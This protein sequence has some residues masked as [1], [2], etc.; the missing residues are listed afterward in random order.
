MTSMLV[1]T[2]IV[3]DGKIVIALE[4]GYNLRSLVPSALETVKVLLGEP[5]PCIP[6]Q[7][8][9]YN[10]FTWTERKRHDGALKRFADVL[11]RVMY[12]QSRFWNCFKD[13]VPRTT[14]NQSE[15][16]TIG[17]GDEEYIFFQ[18]FVKNST[19]KSYATYLGRKVKKI[20]KG[21]AMHGNVIQ[22]IFQQ[23]QTKWMIKYIDGS[24]RIMS[25][26]NMLKI[27]VGED[28]DEDSD[29]F[30]DM[31]VEIENT[32][33]F[34]GAANE[35]RYGRKS[36]KTGGAYAP[37]KK[38]LAPPES[39]EHAPLP[40]A[41]KLEMDQPYDIK[42]FGLQSPEKS[43]LQPLPRNTKHGFDDLQGIYVQDGSRFPVGAK[44]KRYT[45]D[46]DVV[47]VDK[48]LSA[49]SYAEDDKR[50]NFRAF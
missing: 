42:S 30:D 40:R 41:P 29:A 19:C 16:P 4:G 17:R 11:A 25:H 32:A 49:A 18:K 50:K 20:I 48:W 6:C 12:E 24:S 1:N 3:K 15:L 35:N 13:L 33:P 23:G 21:E 46:A 5:A 7:E 38:S 27:L 10:F 22:R 44:R 8:H 45:H 26:V 37:V 14:R 36:S 28:L 9:V 47:A 39:V 34:G 2:N 31:V 43:W